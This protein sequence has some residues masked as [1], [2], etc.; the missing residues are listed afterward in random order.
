M[1]NQLGTAI[2]FYDHHLRTIPCSP[3][4]GIHD[5]DLADPLHCQRH[6]VPRDHLVRKVWLRQSQNALEQAGL[7]GELKG[8]PV[9]AD[10]PGGRYGQVHCRPPA[11]PLLRL[12]YDGKDIS[13]VPGKKT[14][15]RLRR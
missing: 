11:S 6:P 10:L 5:S 4:H 2:K 8:D 15:K 13:P 7:F 3:L 12:P 14:L 1:H 9:D